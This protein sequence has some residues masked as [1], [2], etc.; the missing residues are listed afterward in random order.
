MQRTR[1]MTRKPK[2]ARSGTTSHPS[3]QS[4]LS[5]MACT[6]YLDQVKIVLKEILGYTRKAGRGEKKGRN[7]RHQRG[8]DP[9]P[10]RF[11]LD[12]ASTQGRSSP[13]S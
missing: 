8:K 4:A 13:N 3:H 1:K 7:P 2:R 10:V 5:P 12:S 9:A 11:S 6:A